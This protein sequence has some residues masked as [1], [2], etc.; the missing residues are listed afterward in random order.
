MSIVVIIINYM[1]DYNADILDNVF[2]ALSNSTRRSIILELAKR[3]LSVNE[4]AEKYDMTLQGVSKHIHV[5]VRSGL[6]S[7]RKDGRTKYCEFNQRHLSAVS[8][9]IK[10][11]QA[12]WEARL[13]ALEDYFDK[14]KT[15][16]GGTQS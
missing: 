10:R 13:D 1:V 14:K 12:F 16:G 3:D 11:Y 7:Q 5:L 6:V 2:H 4:L 8:D 9:L 15:T